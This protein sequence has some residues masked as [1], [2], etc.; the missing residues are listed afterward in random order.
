MVR[1]SSSRATSMNARCRASGVRSS[2]DALATKADHQAAR[3][4][5]R[6][7]SAVAL[8]QQVV[9][10]RITGT[11]GT[12]VAGP[13]DEGRG[14]SELAG[15]RTQA[16]AAGRVPSVRVIRARLHVGQPRAQRVRAYLAP[17]NGAQAGVPLEHRAAIAEIRSARVWHTR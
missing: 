1:S 10:P 16:V 12:E 15:E 6:L 5:K 3:V 4:R 7:T 17:L 13:G 14:D 11:I 2:C 9:R 8:A